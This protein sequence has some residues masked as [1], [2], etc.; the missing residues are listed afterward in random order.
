MEMVKIGKIVNTHGLK[1]ELKIIPS[2]HFIEE[3]FGKGA[4]ILIRKDSVHVHA[5]VERMRAD[6]G[7]V[8][9]VLEGLN[10]I[11]AVEIYKGCDVFVDK[12]DLHA[13]DEDEV[14]YSQLMDCEVYTRD[15]VYVGRVVDVIE[16]GANAVLRV[17][18]ESDSVLIP[19]VKVVV[20]AVDVEEKRIE[21]E[22]MEGLL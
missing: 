8:Y 5:K 22:A 20:T 12:A 14:Y 15:A 19:Y 13:L 6:R 3:R 1:G 16:T 7:M 10:D 11:N 18:R 21:I 9:V 2:T 17:Q 4:S